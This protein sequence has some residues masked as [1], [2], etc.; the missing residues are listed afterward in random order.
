MKELELTLR[1]RNNRLKQRREALGMTQSQLSEAAGVD[2][3]TYNDLECL[4]GSPRSR[5]G[6]WKKIAVDLATFH[7]VEPEE[8][9][10]P[11]VEAIARP[12]A[13]RRIDG[14]DIRMLLTSYQERSIE[15]P[16]ADY[17]HTE[18]CKHI[19]SAMTWL[20]RD[21][22]E[23]LRLRYGIDDGEFKTL[24]EVGDIVNLSREQVRVKENRGLRALRN[25][26]N[27][28]ALKAHWNDEL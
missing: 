22:A 14:N 1:V 2:Y 12:V 21:D 26:R 19:K 5:R 15:G 20:R 4:R 3:T 7:C 9:F 11:V 13:M 16:S 6:E 23:V 18:L 24:E 28:K 17:K 8:L 10:P 25:S 27:A